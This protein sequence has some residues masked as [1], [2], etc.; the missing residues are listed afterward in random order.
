MSAAPLLAAIAGFHALLVVAIP[1]V[2]LM[3]ALAR[4][5]LFVARGGK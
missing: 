2:I 1:A 4:V 3:L 5:A